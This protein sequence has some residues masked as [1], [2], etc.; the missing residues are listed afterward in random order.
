MYQV[1]YSKNQRAYDSFTKRENFVRS[2]PQ[3]KIVV[4]SGE[5]LK[6]DSKSMNRIVNTESIDL[7][8]TGYVIVDVS[9]ITSAYNYFV[10]EKIQILTPRI[11]YN[12]AVSRGTITVAAPNSES[13]S[14]YRAKLLGLPFVI[15]SR[16]DEIFQVEASFPPPSVKEEKIPP[17]YS[18]IDYDSYLHWPLHQINSKQAWQ[19]IDENTNSGSDPVTIVVFD[20]R[21]DVNHPDLVGKIAPESRNWFASYNNTSDWVDVP[22]TFLNSCATQGVPIFGWALNKFL[23]GTAISGILGGNNSNNILM[24]S[25]SNDCVK[26][27]V[28]VIV[29][30]FFEGQSCWGLENSLPPYQPDANNAL[31]LTS[32]VL[33]EMLNY[34]TGE[35]DSSWDSIGAFVLNYSMRYAPDWIMDKWETFCNRLDTMRVVGGVAKGVPLFVAHGNNPYNWDDDNY[36]FI[37]FPGLY[38]N[39]FLINAS[40]VN[41]T[42]ASYSNYGSLSFVSAPGGANDSGIMTIGVR[43]MADSNLTSSYPFNLS[44][45]QALKKTYGTSLSTAY[46]AA[47]WATMLYV[48][49]NLTLFQ[50]IEILKTTSQKTGGY[51]YD[52]EGKSL[53]FGYGV[54]DHEAA[55]QAVIEI[56]EE[57]YDWTSLETIGVTITDFDGIIFEGLEGTSTVSCTV[58]ILDEQI[59]P[60]LTTINTDVWVCDDEF[61]DYDSCDLVAQNTLNWEIGTF[62]AN[63][64]SFDISP[65]ATCLL[66]PGPSKVMFVKSQAFGG[67]IPLSYGYAQDSMMTDVGDTDNSLYCKLIGI[68]FDILGIFSANNGQPTTTNQGVIWRLQINTPNYIPNVYTPE[69]ANIRFFSYWWND[70]EQEWVFLNAIDRTVVNGQIYTPW[71]ESL[72]SMTWSSSSIRSFYFHTPQTLSMPELYGGL[73][74]RIK[75]VMVYAIFIN[76]NSQ[77]SPYTYIELNTLTHGSGIEQEF[78]L[79]SWPG[80]SSDSNVG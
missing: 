9:D 26:V 1:V 42:K 35:P 68:N 50:G 69:W 10:S 48:R 47:V 76:D 77:I 2:Y 29:D 11:S 22:L 78:L 24:L 53:E 4:F 31:F 21:V 39:T 34:W 80:L 6:Y 16:L 65:T 25:P 14:D 66:E 12:P 55:I 63:S 79:T 13:I 8:P 23:H 49:P 70:S 51:T 40:L 19:L 43:G 30:T 56:S 41:Q 5:T 38:N 27:R 44:T 61:F 67:T 52:E 7:I 33:N 74:L 64:V 72:S 32:N 36:E 71:E 46:V 73:P 45:R 17:P 75:I 54:I 37:P 60:L 57:G 58:D 3:L 15:N 20:T 28:E 59:K 18:N 62:S